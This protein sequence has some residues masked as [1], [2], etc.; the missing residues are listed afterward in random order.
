MAVPQVTATG[1]SERLRMLGVTSASRSA[2]LPE[3]PAIAETLPGYDMAAWRSIMGPA[4]LLAD[5][6]TVLH[7]EIQKALAAS[8]LR[9]RYAKAASTPLGST[10]AELRKR[11]AEWASILGRIAREANL[12][13]Q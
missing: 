5:L 11:Y 7:R 3:I 13:P 6:I 8:E 4:G 2:M 1:V 9:E 10:P 12:R